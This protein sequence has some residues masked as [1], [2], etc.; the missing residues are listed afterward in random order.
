M[1]TDFIIFKF[2]GFKQVKMYKNLITERLILKPAEVGFADMLLAYHIRNKDFLQPWTPKRKEEFFTLS[3]QKNLL[4]NRVGLMNFGLEL[5]LYVFKKGE[6]Q[7]IIGDIGFS[8]IVKGAFQSCFLGYALDKDNINQGIMEE[9]L[10]AVIPYF[11]E[12]FQLHRIE[13]NVLP[14]NGASIRLLEKLGFE[15]EGKAKKYFQ[16]NGIWEDHLHYALLNEAVE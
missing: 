4:S 2:I 6:E 1:N 11:F 8:N 13:A 16:I 14:R 10:K 9:A 15:Y 12:T 5:R 3:H 7:K